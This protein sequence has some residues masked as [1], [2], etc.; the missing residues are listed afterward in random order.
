MNFWEINP[1]LWHAHPLAEPAGIIVFL[2]LALIAAIL[3]PP[4]VWI[5]SWWNRRPLRPKRRRTSN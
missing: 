2:V 4:V 5:V 1:R 3:G